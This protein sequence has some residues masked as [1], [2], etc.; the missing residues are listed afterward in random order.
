MKTCKPVLMKTYKSM[1]YVV[2]FALVFTTAATAADNLIPSKHKIITFDAPGAG[3]GSGQGTLPFSINPAGK[4]TGFTRDSNLVRHGFFRDKHGKVTVFDD[5]NAGTGSGQGTRGYTINPKGAITGYY[6]DSSG[7]DH[8]FLRAPDGKITN[9]DAPDAG[10]GAGQGTYPWGT[11][12]INPSGVITGFYIDSNNA[13]NGFLRAPDGS[14]LYE[15]ATGTM[16]FRGE[17]S[18]VIFKAILDGTPTP[19]V[20]LNPDVPIKLEENPLK[21]ELLGP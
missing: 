2:G 13:D 10:T 14:V 12:D 18:G 8:G 1:L 7:V 21:I 19:A 20:R 11:D 5:P 9:F 17:S 3:K 15:M 6:T 4:I 16:A